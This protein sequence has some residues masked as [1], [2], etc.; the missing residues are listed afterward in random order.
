MKTEF[1]TAL[2]TSNGVEIQATECD[3][4]AH[5]YR[6]RFEW[7]QAKTG[8]SRPQYHQFLLETIEEHPDINLSYWSGFRI[9]GYSREERQERLA[10]IP[11]EQKEFFGDY[12]FYSVLRCVFLFQRMDWQKRITNHSY[13]TYSLKH[14]FEDWYGRGPAWRVAHI[15]GSEYVADMQVKL[16]AYLL[17][18][19]GFR[20]GDEVPVTPTAAWR[21][22][23]NSSPEGYG[24]PTVRGDRCYRKPESGGGVEEVRGA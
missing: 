2:K 13:R 3:N 6:E 5:G 17:K 16:A 15:G 22:L 19:P 18:M 8:V 24:M 12:Y 21:V 1:E 4:L 20:G 7:L 9:R 23:D 14:A 11:E 10:A